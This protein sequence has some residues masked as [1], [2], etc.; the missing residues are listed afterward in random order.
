MGRGG[1]RSS[2]LVV[3]GGVGVIVTRRPAGGFEV[4][5]FR[6]LGSESNGGKIV[7]GTSELEHW[8]EVEGIASNILDVDTPGP[9]NQVLGRLPYE[10][11][12]GRVFPLEGM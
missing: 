2:I 4:N 3:G 1:G 10:K 5:H 6:R 7:T 9:A 8:A 11:I 12:R